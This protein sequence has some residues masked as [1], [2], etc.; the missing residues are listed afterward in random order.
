MFDTYYTDNDNCSIYS[1]SLITSIYKNI[2]NYMGNISLKTEDYFSENKLDNSYSLFGI[3]TNLLS[4]ELFDITTK[5]KTDSN[6]KKLIKFICYQKRLYKKR[7]NYKK[8][9]RELPPTQYFTD[10]IKKIISNV[11]IS[12]KIKESF[13]VD[14]NIIKIEENMSDTNFLGKKRIKPKGQKIIKEKK[15]KLGRKKKDDP[16]GNHTKDAIDNIIK[17]IKTS[18]L[19]YL[20]E[21][22]NN[23]LNTFINDDN[24]ILLY[25]N[26]KRKI[27]DKKLIKELDYDNI[28]NNVKKEINLEFLKMS[29]KDFLSQDI[30]TKYR[31]LPVDSNKILIEEIIKIEKDNEIIMFILKDFTIGNWIDVFTYKKELKDFGNLNEEKIKKIMDKFIRVDK[32]LEEIYKLN[33]ENNY[34]SRFFII[35]Y[36]Y[37]RYFFIKRERQKKLKE[38]QNNNEKEDAKVI[39]IK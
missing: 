7:S 30:T 33:N 24:K 35:L 21:F 36:N 37:E 39:L 12:N 1:S 28:V 23:L 11:N 18:L 4:N 34:F 25:K 8:E 17:K 27:Q 13:I 5:F 29:L 32:L 26:L 38:K 16:K 9:K 3:K 6:K 2:E 10:K 15:E 20:I 14:D 31:T 22:I 19:N